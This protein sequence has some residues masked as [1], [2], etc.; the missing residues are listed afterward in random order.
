MKHYLIALG[1]LLTLN[2]SAAA[3]QPRHRHH[4]PVEVTDTTQNDALEAYSDTTSNSLDADEDAD[5]DTTYSV[6][7]DDGIDQF[8]TGSPFVDSLLKHLVEGTLGTGIILI[9]V[10]GII[11]VLLILLAPII[12]VVMLIRYLIN[13]HNNRVSMAEKAMETGQPLPEE[14][15]EEPKDADYYRKKGIQNVAL[16]IGI[17]IIFSIWDSDLVMSL[18]ILVLCFGIGQLVIAKTSK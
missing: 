10:L 17:I 3:L 8:D 7:A 6:N 5:S 11:L 2:V 12:V 13:Q 16:G 18:G 4:A 1:L 9:L 15:K 14:V